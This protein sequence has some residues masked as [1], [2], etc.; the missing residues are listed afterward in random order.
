MAELT[1]NEE[2]VSIL[3]KTDMRVLFELAAETT[4]LSSYNWQ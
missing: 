3:P 1:V 4:I 2:I